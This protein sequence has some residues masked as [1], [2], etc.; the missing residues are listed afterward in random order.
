MS[1][2]LS[3][4][5][6]ILVTGGSG[7]VGSAIQKISIDYPSY[8]FSFVSSKQYNL[9]NAEECKNMFSIVKPFKKS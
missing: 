4:K 7:L 5:K 2:S 1:P 9:L 3:K 8:D 6:T